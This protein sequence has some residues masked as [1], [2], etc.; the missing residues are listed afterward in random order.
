LWFTT[1][2]GVAWI[3]PANIRRNRLAPPVQ[4]RA[5]SAEG[6]RYDAGEHVTLPARTTQLQLAYT[7]PSLARPDLVRFRYR[8]SKVDTAW[9][10]AGARREAF[11]TNLT[12]GSYQFRVIAANE[13]GVWNDA[14]ASL[15]LEIPPSFTQTKAFIG[16]VAGLIA[17]ALV[18]AG[19]LLALWRQ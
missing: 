1:T 9:V 5:V 18:A 11:Y 16:L 4:V 14:G 8:L 17:A 15:D 2:T 10:D 13:D 19:W 12:P 6:K 7:S 3:D